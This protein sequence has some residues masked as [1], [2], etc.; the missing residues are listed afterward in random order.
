MK[1]AI[2]GG[3]GLRTPLIVRSMVKRQK[4]LG[5]TELCLMDTSAHQL[6]VTGAITSELEK[7][8]SL[9]D[10]NTVSGF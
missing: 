4:Q 10:R 3:A 6:E 5:L 1:I 7:N 9:S 2:L 8:S